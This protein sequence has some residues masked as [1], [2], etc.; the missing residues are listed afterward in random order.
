MNKSIYMSDETVEKLDALV[1]YY[2][3]WFSDAGLKTKLSDS[4]VIM[5]CIDQKYDTLLQLGK[6]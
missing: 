5:N 1:K 3:K 6:I 2:D 4:T